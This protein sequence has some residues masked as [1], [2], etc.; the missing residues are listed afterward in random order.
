MK[1]NVIQQSV[2]ASR[3][4]RNRFRHQRCVCACPFPWESVGLW[5]IVEAESGVS[6]VFWTPGS[7][8]CQR[9]RAA[10]RKCSLL[11]LRQPNE[12]SSLELESMAART[13]LWSTILSG[14]VSP[15]RSQNDNSVRETDR[16]KVKMERLLIKVTSKI[17]MY[18]SHYSKQNHIHHYPSFPCTHIYDTPPNPSFW[19]FFVSQIR[20]NW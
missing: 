2:Q 1:D 10:S 9:E 12:S 19:F 7:P 18:L 15:G 5:Q 16:E 8:V 17:N 3:N 20:S 14:V 4:S 11:T 13:V 6:G